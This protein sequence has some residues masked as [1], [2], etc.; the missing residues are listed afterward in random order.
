MKKI[1]LMLIV[2]A[3]VCGCK[4]SNRKWTEE[5]RREAKQMLELY[6]DLV[7]LQDLTEAEYLL[8]ADDVVD[9][10]QAEFPSYVTFV[11]MPAVNDTIETYVVATIVEEIQADRR[12]MRHVFPYQ[13]LVKNNILP[14]GMPREQIH[15]FYDCLAQ[16][17]NSY[18]GS[19]QAF[20][21][22]ALN[23]LLDDVAIVNFQQKCAAPYWSEETITVIESN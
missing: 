3:T 21:Y 12:N 20:V 14:E 5:Q 2:V 10:L 13:H 6:R 17:V 7:Y 23:S 16:H 8:F 18:F 1:V 11:A 22:G 15:E 19:Y 4:N 9:T